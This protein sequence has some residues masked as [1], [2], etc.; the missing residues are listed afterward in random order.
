MQRYNSPKELEQAVS[1]F[2][3]A[4]GITTIFDSF[5]AQQSAQN[6]LQ[7]AHRHLI[8][9]I[10][11]LA[12]DLP[13]ELMEVAQ[14]VTENYREYPLEKFV[15]HMKIAFNI[16]L[17]MATEPLL[18]YVGQIQGAKDIESYNDVSKVLLMDFIKDSIVGI[19]STSYLKQ[20]LSEIEDMVIS[21]I[22]K[23]IEN[24]SLI[25]NLFEVLPDDIKEMIKAM[26]ADDDIDG[27]LIGIPIPNDTD[28]DEDDSTEEE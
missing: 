1:N 19:I 24:K 7:A 11:G 2:C 20:L 12:D 21:G 13:K 6:E 28:S 16:K 3:E 14:H 17:L 26:A 10:Q 9:R 25:D 22:K 4:F 15:E 18:E 27:V 5:L 23:E 8:E